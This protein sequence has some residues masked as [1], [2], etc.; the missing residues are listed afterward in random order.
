[1]RDIEELIINRAVLCIMDK[2]QKEPMIPAIEM[3]LTEE[4]YGYFVK[5]LMRCFADEDA[6]PASFQATPNMLKDMLDEMMENEETFV[7]NS[8]KI[9]RLMLK[10]ISNEEKEPSGDLAILEF[11]CKKGKFIGLLKLNFSEG[12]CHFMSEE[13]GK[14][15]IG[16]E[17]NAV[18]LPGPSQKVQR[19]MIYGKN[20]EIFVYDKD[21]ES[22]FV[23]GF[24]RMV[25]GRD[26]RTNLKAVRKAVE[27]FARKAYEEDPIEAE[28]FRRKI[29]E[30]L[31]TEDVFDVQ[32]VASQCIE[33]T[34]KQ[35]IFTKT[36]QNSGIE[37]NR[38][39]IDREWA[40]KK[41]QRKRLKMDKD[42][43]LYIDVDAYNDKERFKISKNG[44]GTID[45]VLKN[46][47]SFTEK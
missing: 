36:I 30:R 40:E 19:V 26:E 29:G 39:K 46:I 10:A 33:D 17:K 45:I 41:M 7:L 31:R 42:I 6:R 23:R 43:D 12:Y 34:E 3:I 47:R 32:S 27:V 15:A 11:E 8:G 37:E 18:V 35:E 4:N 2:N 22:W 1:M 44:D 21:M 16:L 14:M 5:H 24:G 9:S 38:I 20:E 13:N 28:S 25:P